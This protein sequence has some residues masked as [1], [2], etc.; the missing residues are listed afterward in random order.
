MANDSV[1]K[2]DKTNSTIS[3]GNGIP[4][5]YILTNTKAGEII[6][7]ACGLCGMALKLKDSNMGV[8]FGN[9][10]PLNRRAPL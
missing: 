6:V 7:F 5:I 1:V 9:G 8:V 3:A 4:C 10:T 2:Y